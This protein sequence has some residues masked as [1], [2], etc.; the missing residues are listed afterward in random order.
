MGN[1]FSSHLSRLEY[2]SVD[3]SLAVGAFA[4]EESANSIVDAAHPKKAT[5]ID[6]GSLLY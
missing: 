6:V 3:V 1:V 4:G 5:M 2:S